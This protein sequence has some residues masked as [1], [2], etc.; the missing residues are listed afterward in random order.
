[1]TKLAI[2]SIFRSLADGVQYAMTKLVFHVT[3]T[4]QFSML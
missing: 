2:A 4:E 3:V 1:M